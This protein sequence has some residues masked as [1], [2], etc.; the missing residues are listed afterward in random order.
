M[1]LTDVV[2]VEAECKDA[3]ALIPRRTAWVL[4]QRCLTWELVARTEDAG[5]PR[6]LAFCQAEYADSGECPVFHES[7]IMKRGI[8]EVSAL[9]GRQIRGTT[10]SRRWR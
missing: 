9:T 2:P 8:V 5:E 1:T 7:E 3:E 10:P 4:I 6:T